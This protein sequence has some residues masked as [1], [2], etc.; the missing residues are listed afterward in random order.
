VSWRV[1]LVPY[2]IALVTAAV[3][4]R[5]L[6]GT[7]PP[8]GPSVR[9]QLGGL[10]Q[11]VRQTQL[12]IVYI[13]AMLSFVLIFGVFLATLPIHLEDEFGFGAGMRGVFLALPALPS[14]VVAFNIERLRRRTTPRLLLAASAA[15]LAVAFAFMGSTTLAVLVVVG[16]IFHGLGEGALIPT[17]QDIAVTLAPE[18]QR[19]AVVALFVSCARLGQTIGPIGAALVFEA[20][21][22]S[23]ALRL[24]A[25]LAVGLAALF[26]IGLTPRG[27]DR[28]A[29]AGVAT[30]T[31]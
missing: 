14:M 10:G 25:F 30:A 12:I 29:T 11:A 24:G 3:A 15:L 27:R 28:A 16:C 18:S 31:G 22:T 20:T 8:S 23:A 7:R 17:M 9:E 19:G 6:D 13:G 26:L 1:A 4:W 2:G 5:M 21:T